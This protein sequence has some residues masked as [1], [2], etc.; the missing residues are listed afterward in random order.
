MPLLMLEGDAAFSRFRIAG[1]LDEIRKAIP[2]SAIR[3]I[4]AIHVFLVETSGTLS[5]DTQRKTFALLAASRP[6]VL[7]DGFLVTP[8]KGT[9]SPWSSWIRCPTRLR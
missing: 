4:E 5:A 6:F 9:I 7:T 2:A 1:L 3:G 8:R